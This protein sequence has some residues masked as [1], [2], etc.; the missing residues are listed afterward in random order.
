LIRWPCPPSC[1][2]TGISHHETAVR[3][4]SR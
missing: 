1:S 3:V 4:M 2:L